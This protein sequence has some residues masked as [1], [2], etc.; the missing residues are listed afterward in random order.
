MNVLV[1]GG[2]GYLGSH[3]VDRLLD[4]GHSVRVLD[5]LSTGN[6][7]AL[8]GFWVDDRFKFVGG[9]VCNGAVVSQALAGVDAVA[10]LAAVVGDPACGK[11][12]ELSRAVNLEASM[13]LLEASLRSGIGWFVFASTCS[14]YGRMP[15]TDDVLDEAAPLQPLSVYAET[16]V[17]VEQA[18]LEPGRWDGMACTALRLATLFGVSRRMRFDLTVNEFT[19]K[20]DKWPSARGFPAGFLAT[21]PDLH[22]KD[23]ASAIAGVLAAPVDTVQGE[24]F[25]TGSTGQN[26]RKRDL[27]R[28]IAAHIPHALVEFLEGG[29]DPRNYRVSFRKIEETLRFESTRSVPAG[30]RELAALVESGLIVDP[31]SSEYRNS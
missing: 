14:N 24:V 19:L 6:A 7:R 9:S 5:D 10:H 11:A 31:H 3:V 26:F 22:V 23:A 13:N 17:A 4:A 30:I 27:V 18:L 15:G 28:L 20:V 16:K 1:T 12:P 8:L 29:D 2:A 25:N 21:V